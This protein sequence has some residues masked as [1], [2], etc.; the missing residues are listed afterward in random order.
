MVTY[1][2]FF[3]FLFLGGLIFYIYQETEFELFL[4]TS[5]FILSDKATTLSLNVSSL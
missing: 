1:F 2:T 3:L 5:K 4:T